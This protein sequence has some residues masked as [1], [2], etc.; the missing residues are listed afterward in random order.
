[1]RLVTI[2]DSITRGTYTEFGDVSPQS[3][4]KPC[5]AEIL[6]NELK[7]EEL[8]NYGRNGISYSSL[9]PVNSDFALSKSIASFQTGDY[10]IVAAGTND[11][12][13]D[14][15]LGSLNDEGD[16]SFAG[17]VGA[18]FASLKRRNPK[19]DFF[20]ITPISRGDKKMNRLGYFL[21]DY[22]RMIE[23]R[24]K[25]YGFC[26]IRG[27]NFTIDPWN[28]SD[29]NEYMFDGVHLNGKGHK[30][31]AQFIVKEMLTGDK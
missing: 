9:S 5:F 25:E 12:G 8:I 15:P 27:E 19:A 1:M 18:V 7:C 21:D 11:F 30:I 3:I 22:R 6:K 10:V 16:I 2:G 23:L 13:T 14:V 17:A 20:A 29:R 24:A 28:V 26:I 31:Y 4:A